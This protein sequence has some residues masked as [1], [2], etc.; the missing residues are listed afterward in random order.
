MRVTAALI[1]AENRIF[2]AQRP[3]GKK[4]A[5]QWEFPG[6]KVERDEGLRE[7]V[8]REIREELCWEVAVGDLFCRSRHSYTDFSIELYA[9]WCGIVRGTLCLREHIGFRWASIAEL[10]RFHFTSADLEVV[11]NLERL[12]QLP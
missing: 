7:S 4:F 6:G 8:A 2:I 1:C 3:P 10:S 9:Y 5:F 11:R 12:P